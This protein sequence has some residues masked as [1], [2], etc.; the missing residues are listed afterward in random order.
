MRTSSIA[1]RVVLALAAV[2]VPVA[3]A[4]VVPASGHHTAVGAPAQPPP[5]PAP[6]PSPTPNP[7]PTPGPNPNP[8]PVPGPNPNPSPVPPH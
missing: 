1:F 7:S 5:R 4:A 2:G 6:T 3:Q 8:N